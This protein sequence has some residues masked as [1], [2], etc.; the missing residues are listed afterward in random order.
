VLVEWNK[1][2]SKREVG[3]ESPLVVYVFSAVLDFL[4]AL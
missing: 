1:I 2:F 3:V 4:A